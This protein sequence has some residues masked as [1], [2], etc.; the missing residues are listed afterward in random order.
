MPPAVGRLISS[1]IWASNESWPDR[2]ERRLFAKEILAM[3]AM[4]I[5]PLGDGNLY[6]SGQEAEERKE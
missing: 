3:A 2:Q 5:L 6:H 1:S 4:R